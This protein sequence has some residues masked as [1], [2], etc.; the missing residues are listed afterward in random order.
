MN[1]KTLR[2]FL[3]DIAVI[4]VSLAIAVVLARTNA[5]ADFLTSTRELRLLGSFI[6]GL[7]F[8]SAFTTAPAIVALGA[9]ASSG[10]AVTTAAVGA[11]GAVLGDLLLF[12]IVRDRLSAH[13][14]Q[15]LKA[16]RGWA[17]FVLLMRSTSFRWMSFFIGGVIIASP[18]PDEIG[19]GMLGFSKMPLAWFA[20]LSYVFNFIGIL[21]IGGIVKALF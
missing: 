4:L 13:L 3:K 20:A 5:I 11:L 12:A 2:H 6:A 7:F 8:T 10:N 9:I 18:L 14:A 19:I 16:S 17:R 15:H 21:A 1:A